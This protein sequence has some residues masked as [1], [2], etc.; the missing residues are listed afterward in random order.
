MLSFSSPSTHVRIISLFLKCAFPLGFRTFVP[1]PL[2]LV[3]PF[4]FPTLCL[5]FSSWCLS[6]KVNVT[7]EL[8]RASSL[9]PTVGLQLPLLY[10][11][12]WLL[13]LS[14]WSPD[15]SSTEAT[16]LFSL[17]GP[18]Q[19][20]CVSLSVDTSLPWSNLGSPSFYAGTWL[21]LMVTIIRDPVQDLSPLAFLCESSFPSMLC[22]KSH[23]P[24]RRWG[25]R[26]GLTPILYHR[27]LCRS[28]D[29]KWAFCQHLRFMWSPQ[30]YRIWL[31]W[32]PTREDISF[33]PSHLIVD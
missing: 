32:L 9:G 30:T 5:F 10:G 33:R 15:Q 24:D 4:L 14:S 26:Q 6:P 3:W 28:A 2:L 1:W 23:C 21:F 12:I 7:E 31:H 11:G 29:T 17:I 19:P 8:T 16:V 25:L 27:L 20:V 22:A 13:V 18:N